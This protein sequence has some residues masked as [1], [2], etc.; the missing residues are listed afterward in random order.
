R[1][2]LFGFFL[3]F[4]NR[5]SRRGSA[6]TGLAHWGGRLLAILAVYRA[7]CVTSLKAER[8]RSSWRRAWILIACFC[9]AALAP[10]SLRS[11]TPSHIS[12]GHSVEAK[13]L[14]QTG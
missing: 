9:F 3:A 10:I 14:Y 6:G 11:Q 12:P 2:L 1:I 13:R 7:Q 5:G 4:S 8:V